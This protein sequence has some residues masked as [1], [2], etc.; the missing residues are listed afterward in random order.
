MS[1]LATVVT[2]LLF[3][4]VAPACTT[5]VPTVAGSGRLVAEQRDVANFT[6][7]RVSTAIKATILV[8]PDATVQVTADDNLLG[9][10]KTDL[11]AGRLDISLSPGAQPST[12]V[13]VAV[14]V[15]NLEDLEV[16]SAA[17]AIAT[18]INSSNFQAEADSAG[19]LTA[20]GN[21]DSVEVTANS[22]GSA[23][24]G[25][26]PAQTATANVGSGASATVNAQLTVGGSVDS[27]GILHIKGQPQNVNVTTNSG[28]AVI[29]D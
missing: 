24:L 4:L 3:A 20:R 16:N 21:A 14:T 29:R 13:E 1:R 5:I 7:V 22:A 25:G 6:R 11:T 2:V 26:V 23:D 9:S 18:G 17:S 15:P 10:V 28:G 8:G 12:A 19:T 27:G